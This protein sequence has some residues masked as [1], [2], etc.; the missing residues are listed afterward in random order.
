MRQC[1]SLSYLVG[2]YIIF[3]PYFPAP[4]KISCYTVHHNIQLVYKHLRIL[5]MYPHFYFLIRWSLR[6]GRCPWQEQRRL[7]KKLRPKQ[8]LP[9]ASV[10]PQVGCKLPNV[11]IKWANNL[12][13][14]HHIWFFGLSQQQNKNV[15]ANMFFVETSLFRDLIY[16][17]PV[18]SVKILSPVVCYAQ[19]VD[20]WRS[21]ALRTQGSE[22]GAGLWWKHIDGSIMTIWALSKKV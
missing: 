13:L 17:S 15:L 10:G 7:A 11:G 3:T 21:S 1:T 6:C 20:I 12:D 8:T 16:Q 19:G 18:V 14:N 4:E 2:G 5:L 22:F 9:R